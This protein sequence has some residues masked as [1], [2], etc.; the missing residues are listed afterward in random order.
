MA[1]LPASFYYR[2]YQKQQIS[3][4]LIKKN[5][6]KKV[7]VGQEFRKRI[8]LVGK[9][10][11]TK[12]WEVFSD[13]KTPKSYSLS[14]IV[15]KLGA[16]CQGQMAQ[17]SWEKLDVKKH[18]NMLELKVAKFAMMTFT[19]MF[20]TAKTIHLQIDN[21]VVLSNLLKM[22]GHNKILSDLRNLGLCPSKWDHN[23][24]RV[25]IGNPE[26]ECRSAVKI[27]IGLE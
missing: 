23:Y 22:G 5:F 18:K 26:F 21:I 7:S 27:H 10:S 25:F 11:E 14:C 4:I 13:H 9:K 20:P 3:E 19:K 2:S 8:S 6:E 12:K 24:C 17:E 16:F 15:E 1:V